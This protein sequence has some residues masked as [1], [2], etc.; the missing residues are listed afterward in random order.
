MG[1]S[2]RPTGNMKWHD[3]KGP[4]DQWQSHSNLSADAATELVNSP[5]VKIDKE[6]PIGLS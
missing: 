6:S 5:T 2:Q 1:K 3:D 4:K